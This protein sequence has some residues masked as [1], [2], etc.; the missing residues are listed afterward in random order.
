MANDKNGP[1]YLPP[2]RS[3]VERLNRFPLGAPPSDT[4]YAILKILFSE[5][6]AGLV[7]QLPIKPFRISQAARAWKMNIDEARKILDGLAERAILVDCERNGKMIYTLP[8]PMAGFFEFSLMRYRTDVDQQKLSELY[9]QYCTVEDDFMLSIVGRGQT[10]LGRVFVNET[11]LPEVHVLDYERASSVIATSKHM[12]VSLC[13]CRHK[14]TRMG[15]VC[16]APIEDICM[17][18]NDV[19]D[20]LVRH[21]FA[22]SVDPI[23]GKDLLEKAI[24][25]SLVQFGENSRDGVSF[26]CNC[27][28][29]CCEALKAAR[30]FSLRQPIHSSNFI[31]HIDQSLCNG[32][33]RCVDICP[34]G[35]MTLVSA[36][37]PHHP[38]SKKARL[39]EDL[40][41]GCGLCVRACRHGSLSLGQRPERIITPLNSIHRYV[42]MG[43]E[44]GNLQDMLFDERVFWS[45]RTLAAVLGVILRLPPVQKMI[46]VQLMKSRYLESL[47]ARLSKENI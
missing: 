17:T 10:Q 36:N 45:H 19:A 28:G 34:M 5:R 43:V 31:P 16:N 23:E 38:R 21:G 8:P 37:D 40:C 33:T 32:C 1:I 25:Y 6:E 24:E 9:H 11:V 20:S 7:A 46:A 39:S 22:R 2:Y 44:R 29:C 47:I 42:L 27:C 35:A 26:I 18:F 14:A 30:R 12:A 15:D 3:L 13:F 41:L 4:L